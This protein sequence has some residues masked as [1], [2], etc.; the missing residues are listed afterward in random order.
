M[1]HQ[2]P[3][4]IISTAELIPLIGNPAKLSAGERIELWAK[5][6]ERHGGPLSALR[7]LEHLSS[8]E[9]RAYRGG[10][11][12]LTVAFSDP[13]LRAHGLKGDSLGD[14][15]DFFAL[16]DRDAHWLLC[17]CHHVGTMT[18]AGLAKRLRHHARWS[19]RR[20]RW[21]GA[22]MRFFGLAR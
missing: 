14:A 22:V 11:T 13:V 18:G 5:A 2:I 7:R 3:D 15:M 20:A 6:L 16:S 21:S 19:E 8:D 9:L 12:P 17:D 10:N 1:K 4:E